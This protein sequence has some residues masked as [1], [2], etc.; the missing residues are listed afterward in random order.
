MKPDYYLQLKSSLLE[1]GY[2]NE[3]NWQTNLQPVTESEVFRDETIWV[4]LN[5]GMKE[6]IARLI[7]ERIKFAVKEGIDISQAFGHKGKVSAI[8]HIYL[9]YQSIFEGYLNAAHKIEYLQEIPF[10]G[11]ITKYHL[12]KNLGHDCVKPDRHLVRIAKGYLM[13]CED[14]C[15]Q[16]SKQT[17]DKVSVV[18]I[19]LWRSA[20][21][22][23]I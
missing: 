21:L 13:T 1:E 15:E 23:W 4:I 3:I 18:D 22:G 7:W 17:G 12:A 19:V 5:S 6:Q 8:K 14:M 11:G 20:N 2:E 10:I 16:L 9:N